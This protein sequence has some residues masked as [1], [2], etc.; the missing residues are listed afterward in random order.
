MGK[1]AKYYDV[2]CETK[3][4]TIKIKKVKTSDLWEIG[5]EYR[6]VDQT[7]ET[8][9]DGPAIVCPKCRNGFKKS[10]YDPRWKYCPHC[11]KELKLPYYR[12]FV[13]EKYS[14]TYGGPFI[15]EE[16]AD[17]YLKGIMIEGLGFSANFNIVK[18]LM[19][20]N[21]ILDEIKEVENES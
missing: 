5:S 2:T 12:Y 3:C 16:N 14:N 15:S 13:Y 9:G 19:V 20:D 10:Y 21:Y 17:Q 11:S 4:K 8:Y 7:G 18:L 6:S 1:E